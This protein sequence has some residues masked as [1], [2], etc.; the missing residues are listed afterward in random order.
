VCTSALAA[1]WH[2][3]GVYPARWVQTAGPSIESS[4]NWLSNRQWR[5]S[6]HLSQSACCWV[7][8][9]AH[10]PALMAMQHTPWKHP[11]DGSVCKLSVA[12]VDLQ[13]AQVI[14]SCKMHFALGREQ[15][16][17]VTLLMPGGIMF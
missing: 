8:S 2:L 9:W 16:S 13:K 5:S 12:A 3:C 11:P 7:S 14:R 1:L 10:I 15:H 4:N 17:S 6:C